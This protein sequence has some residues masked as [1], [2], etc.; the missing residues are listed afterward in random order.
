M[1]THVPRLATDPCKISAVSSILI[2][3]TM[4]GISTLNSRCTWTCSKIG[5]QPALNRSQSGFESRHVY[6]G[7]R[8][9][10]ESRPQRECSRVAPWALPR[11]S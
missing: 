10:F 11:T 2:V 7:G 5:L 9:E 4:S 8:C 3:S 1:G 6:Q